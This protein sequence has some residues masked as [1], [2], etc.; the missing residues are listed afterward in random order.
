MRI[1]Q[2]LLMRSRLSQRGY[3]LVE[4]LVGVALG[5]V[6][7]GSL[8][9]TLLLSELKVSA[10]IQRNLD[11]KDDA[12]RAIDLMR[13]EAGFSRFI[14]KQTSPFSSGC[15]STPLGL[16]QPGDA[17]APSLCYK[18]LAPSALDPV[19]NSSFK[20]PCVLVR[21]G[22]PYKPSG[23]L[24]TAASPVTQVV[25]DGINSSSTSCSSA[26]G[27][28]V[29]LGS[30]KGVYRNADIAITQVQNSGII[31]ALKPSINYNYSLRVPSSPQYDGNEVYSTSPCATSTGCGATDE[32]TA[33]FKPLMGSA[34]ES[35]TGNASKENVF[36]FSYPYSEYSLQGDSSGSSCTYKQ[37]YVQR[38]GA[39]VQLTNVDVLIFAD[40]EIRPNT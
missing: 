31:G 29:T 14:S 36:Y 28:T 13:R 11:S 34:S 38:N 22:P 6:V 18:T 21:I 26:S 24:D 39:A 17:N 19:Y 27:F 8:G 3:T 37:C 25:L 12:S 32:T 2:S 10:N 16:Y 20:G 35:F 40:R 4:L 7:L 30:G 1:N 15:N 9:G 23:V 33:H 5:S